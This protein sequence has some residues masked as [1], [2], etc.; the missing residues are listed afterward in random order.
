LEKLGHLGG[1][2]LESIYL[3]YDRYVTVNEVGGLHIFVAILICKSLIMGFEHMKL[4][5]FGRN[6]I[7]IMFLMLR[8]HISI[9]CGLSII[10]VSFL[11]F[12]YFAEH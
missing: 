6:N 4:I 7:L 3:L 11:G 1:F 8:L 2:L 9:V 10:I 5:F 12:K